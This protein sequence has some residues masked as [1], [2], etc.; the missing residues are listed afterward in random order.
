LAYYKKVLQH[1]ET[2]KYIGKLHWFIY[3][4]AI[5]FLILSAVAAYLVS[6][7]PGDMGGARPF[8]LLAFPILALLSFARAWFHQITTEIVVT[9]KRVIHKTGWIARRTEEIN[10][11]KVETVDVVQGISGRIFNFGAVLIKGIGGSWEPLQHIASPL[12]LR[13]AIV[14]G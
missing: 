7:A 3:K 8:V 10:V 2:V 6:L 14:V 5:L 11:S 1:D 13:S 4:Y 12:Q 9:D